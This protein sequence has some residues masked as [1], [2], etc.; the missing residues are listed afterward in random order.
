[1]QIHAVGTEDE[2]F[3]RVRPIFTALEVFL[4]LMYLHFGAHIKHYYLPSSKIHIKEGGY[5]FIL[6]INNTNG[7]KGYNH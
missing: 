1:M 4:I 5:S 2:I 6:L 3:E 7:Q